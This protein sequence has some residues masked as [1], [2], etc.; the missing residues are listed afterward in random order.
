[1]PWQRPLKAYQV[2]RIKQ[3]EVAIAASFLLLMK[4][5]ETTCKYLFG[6]KNERVLQR[7]FHKT[8]QASSHQSLF[9]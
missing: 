3:K 1:M 6:D 7:R 8:Y 2:S 4:I 5:M 9:H